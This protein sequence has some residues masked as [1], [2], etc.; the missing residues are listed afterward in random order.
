MRLSNSIVLSAEIAGWSTDDIQVYQEC[1]D[2]AAGYLSGLVND[3]LSAERMRDIKVTRNR[4]IERHRCL[5]CSEECIE[6]A[7][8]HH[9]N[10]EPTNG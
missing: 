2:K 6:W 3:M 9:W 4:H 1:L 7:R 5:A 8:T 10:E